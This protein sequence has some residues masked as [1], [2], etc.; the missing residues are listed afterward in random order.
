MPNRRG[1]QRS[2]SP[3]R[4]RTR[5]P[6][7]VSPL[8]SRRGSAGASSVGFCCAWVGVRSVCCSFC[9]D[10]RWYSSGPAC[11]CPGFTTTA[12]STSSSGS[13][14]RKGSTHWRVRMPQPRAV[15]LFTDS[16][17]FGGAEKALLTLIRGLDRER[18]SPTLVFHTSPGIERLVEGAAAASCQL[19]PV[20]PMPEGLGGARRAV[21]FAAMLARRRP[22]VFHAHLTW[23]LACKF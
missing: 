4:G 22:H 14:S 5:C 17:G 9:R 2:S 19:I 16:S 12:Y 23:P 8:T 21:R 1:R 6:S 18:W 13:A 15:F 3:A 7:Y 10:S 20:A 11:R